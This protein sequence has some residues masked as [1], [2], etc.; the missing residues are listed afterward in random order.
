MFLKGK[1]R[2]KRLSAIMAIV[3][4]FVLVVG[5]APDTSAGLN[6]YNENGYGYNG[7]GNG[8]G[9]NGNGN[10]YD[11]NENGNAYNGNGYNGN[12]YD[13]YDYDTYLYDAEY[14]EELTAA[15]IA[16][17]EPLGADG[18]I[19]LALIGDEWTAAIA[20]VDSVTYADGALTIADGADIPYPVSIRQSVHML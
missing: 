2:G 9:Y 5:M 13:E 17:V 4:A 18:T 1:K 14:A 3:L 12:D 16:A 10:G 8:N 7:N 20:A 11:Y 15:A 19:N 6:G